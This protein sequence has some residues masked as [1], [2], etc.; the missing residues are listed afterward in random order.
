MA[1]H[2]LRAALAADVES[3]ERMELLFSKEPEA[4]A[5][6]F[7]VFKEALEF[8][9]PVSTIPKATLVV[10]AGKLDRAKFSEDLPKWCVSALRELGYEEDKGA[11]ALL[12][13]AGTFKY[14][15]DTGKN[16]KYIHVFPRIT[17]LPATTTEHDQED[18][19]EQDTISGNK[20][21]LLCIESS[22]SIFQEMSAS[23][24]KSWTSKKRCATLL[25]AKLS[26]LE[27]IQSKLTRRVALTPQ[28]QHLF[29]SASELEEKCALLKKE[30]IHLVDE[31]KLNKSEREE[32]M[33]QIK[34]RLKETGGT[35]QMKTRLAKLESTPSTFRVQLDRED[36]MK[37]LWKRTYALD[38]LVEK[39]GPK[40]RWSSALNAQE[41]Q[42]LTE[43]EE[44]DEELVHLIQQAKLWFETEEEL[45]D[46]VQLAKHEVPRP[47]HQE[48]KS[49][50]SSSSV[51]K[52]AA[53][54][55]A[56]TAVGAKSTKSSTTTK[57]S[58][59]GG[60]AAKNSFAALGGDDSD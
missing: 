28:E 14:Q 23:K 59:G 8:P 47:K 38:S 53:S 6:I 37:Q 58:G 56:W 29:D 22:L 2:G 31:N 9:P 50:S 44:W 10:G 55:N 33:E 19:Q 1:S 46:R 39:A 4:K 11:S 52:P 60:S 49:S 3:V 57:S 45:K 15:H 25:Q 42:K 41:V 7:S 17:V 48:Y 24:L 34:S 51:K 32:V 35:E 40:G 18:D 13:C 27:Q 5:F 12:A 30:M 16:E 26:E 54:G 21:E 36:R 43:K 20:E